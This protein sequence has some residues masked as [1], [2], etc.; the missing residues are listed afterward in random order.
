MSKVRHNA[1]VLEWKWNAVHR[2]PSPALRDDNNCTVKAVQNAF[3]W[4]LERAYHHLEAHGRKHGRGPSWNAYKKAVEAACKA[5]GRKMIV[6]DVSS[7]GR[8]IKT[9]QRA[10]SGS[11]TYILGVRGHT[12][13]FNKG[14]TND[15]ADGRRHHIHTIWRIA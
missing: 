13:S 14:Y 7:Y 4:S 2:V 3:G 6:E 10:F 9:A 11:Q 5:T 15:W 8:T 1:H 12:L